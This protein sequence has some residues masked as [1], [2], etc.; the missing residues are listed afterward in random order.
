MSI[1]SVVLDY[2]QTRLTV[3]ET[4]DIAEIGYETIITFLSQRDG[5]PRPRWV[6]APFSVKRSFTNGV[7]RIAKNLTRSP[8]QMHEDWRL[9]MISKGWKYAPIF[10]VEKKTHPQLLPYS[11]LSE[12]LRQRDKLLHSVVRTLIDFRE[13]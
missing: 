8:L 6:D 1:A 13:P 10:N 2:T 3:E 12:G 7:R 11:Y 5:I 4:I 9:F